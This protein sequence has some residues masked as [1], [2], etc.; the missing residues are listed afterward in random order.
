LQKIMSKMGDYHWFFEEIVNFF[1]RSSFLMFY[2]HWSG[3]ARFS[4]AQHT[5]AY[6]FQII[7]QTAQHNL[8]ISIF[9]SVLRSKLIKYYL[10]DFHW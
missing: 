9:L 6:V 8:R 3:D 4:L 7:W 5:K 10:V 2:V 1:D